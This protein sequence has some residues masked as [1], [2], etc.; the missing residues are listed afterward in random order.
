M[1]RTQVLEKAV[2]LCD[3]R[4]IQAVAAALHQD[5]PELFRSRD[6]ARSA[7]RKRLGAQGEASRRGKSDPKLSTIAEGIAKIRR[8][9]PEEDAEITIGTGVTAILSD[10]HIPHHDA[11]ALTLAIEHAKAK[12]ATDIVLN[13][14]MLDSYG[15]SRFT[16]EVGRL[17]YQQE[18]YEL[19]AFLELVRD[20]FPDARIVY[21]LGNHEERLRA[22]ILN[23]CKELADLEALKL[24]NLLGLDE[25]GIE[26]V[27]FNPIKVGKL[28]VLHGHELQHG[29]IAPVNPARG[30]YMRTKANT[31]VGHHHQVSHHS[32]SSLD[33]DQVGCWSV[34]CLCDLRPEYNRFGFL[35]WRHGFAIVEVDDD[36]SFHV[37]NHSI[38]NGRVM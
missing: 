31:L 36:G 17:T 19:R 20:E 16:R 4:P 18:L 15:I 11:K 24:E 27:R 23:G 14:D 28:N 3:K 9:P 29:F 21:K 37:N 38:L 32:E 10:A 1:T 33:G 7:L 35:K 5:H 25:L 13:G 12:G 6:S 22:Y 26:T 30:V 2:A 8:E 34:G